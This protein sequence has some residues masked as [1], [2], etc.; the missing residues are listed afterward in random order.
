MGAVAA[1][2]NDAC[3][4]FFSRGYYTA[5]ETTVRLLRVL[6]PCLGRDLTIPEQVAIL[7]FSHVGHS[8]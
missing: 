3:S 1:P 8:E 6:L 2:I 5:L 4:D 7:F